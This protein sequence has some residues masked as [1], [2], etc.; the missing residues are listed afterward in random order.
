[1]RSSS[2]QGL[3]LLH[4]RR[5]TTGEKKMINR[6]NAMQLAWL[7]ASTASRRLVKDFE[8]TCRAGLDRCR[9]AVCGLCSRRPVSR[10][11][12]DPPR[13]TAPRT[14]RTK[15]TT[16]RRYSAHPFGPQTPGRCNTDALLLARDPSFDVL[17]HRRTSGHTC[18]SSSTCSCWLSPSCHFSVAVVSRCC[19]CCHRCFAA[20]ALC[21]HPLVMSVWHDSS[22]T[23]PGLSDQAPL[24]ML[25]WIASPKTDAAPVGQE[26]MNGTS[27]HLM[28]RPGSRLGHSKMSGDRQ[29][30]VQLMLGAGPPFVDG[31]C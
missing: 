4:D 21:R 27:S 22:S 23:A 12:S 20:T 3:G 17:M 25:V 11:D 5:P 10:A 8:K 13:T 26:T 9:L 19:R 28:C 16:Q 18:L 24:G 30:P 6:R 7:Q 29:P 14:T 2:A 15:S 1:M 31:C